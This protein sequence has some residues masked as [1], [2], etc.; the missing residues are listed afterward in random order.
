L[1]LRG[2][3]RWLDGHLNLESGAGPVTA[4]VVDDLSLDRMRSLVGVLGDPQAAYPVIHLTGTNGKGSTA[5]MVEALL[6]GHGL[7][8]GMY[9]S[10]H[11]ET[12]NERIVW[13]GRPIP[14]EDLASVLSELASFESLVEGDLSWFELVTAAA[15]SWFAQVAVD[16]AVVEVGLLGRYDATNVADGTVAVVTNIGQDHTDGVGDW[17]RKIAEEKAGII[18][19]GSTLVL[20]ETAEDLRA[21]FEAEPHDR[22]W[23]R[24]RDF[25]AL[26][27]RSAVG[28][29]L[30]T[31]TTPLGIHEE[32]FLPLYGEHQGDNLALAIAAAEAFFDR[33][34]DADV[35]AASL[36]ELSV[37]GRFEIVGREPLVVLDGAHNP[38]GVA[39]LTTTLQDDFS[40]VP[41][42]VVVLGILQG[43]DPAAMIEALELSP[44]DVVLCT[45][46]PSPRAVPA[47][48]L[49][50]VVQEAG[51]EVEVIPEMADALERARSLA[52]DEDRIL[53]TG[54]LYAVGAAR[55]ALGK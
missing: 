53:V 49:A 42:T 27:N 31:V 20:G 38:D 41:V 18:K 22:T 24:D 2:A 9:T 39:A 21:V 25:E 45:T 33:P 10:P 29:R 5:R 28:G 30:V 11:L 15:F 43:R 52:G 34:L 4:G 47:A 35:V 13:D 14:D 7:S 46:P 17:R 37:P 36:A 32:V 48:E 51:I 44:Y 23:R 50:A 16:V 3:R 12:L 1:D 19:P 54:S 26:T 55:A 6:R 40:P 8:V